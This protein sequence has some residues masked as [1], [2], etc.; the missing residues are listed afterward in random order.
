MVRAELPG[1]VSRIVVKLGTGVLTDDRKQPDLAQMKQLVDQIAAERKAGR[2]LVLVSSG[3]VGAGMGVLGHSRRPSELA[4]LQACAAVGQSRLMATYENLFSGHGLAVAQILLTHDDLEHHD[5]HLNAR[6]TLL[7]LLDRGVI[8]IINENDVVSFTELK[9]GDNDMLSALVAS[10]LPADLLVILTTV[11]GV[12][13]NFGGP[14]AR[15]LASIEQIDETVQRLAGGTDSPTAVG[16]MASKIQ[17]AKIAVRSGIPLVIASGRK[18]NSLSRI[19]AGEEEGT[20]FVPQPT[21]L[22]GRKRWIAFFHHPR[23]SIFVDGGAKEALRDSGKS[24]LPPGITRCDGD[25]QAGEVVSICDVNGTEF[26][27]GIAAFA[28]GE[29]NGGQLQRVEVVHRDNLVIL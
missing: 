21:R 11:E 15:K 25:F 16:G 28:S 18:R 19:L 9:F 27:R 13:E 20:L 4:E 3:A 14:N 17:A 29:I 7:R 5:R 10:L 1:H 12:M 24:L 23:G 6:N 26:A 8:P 2:E 22:Q